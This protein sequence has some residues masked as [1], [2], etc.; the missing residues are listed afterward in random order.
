MI[1]C[2]SRAARELKKIF[3]LKL[4]TCC[5]VESG[6]SR[7]AARKQAINNQRSRNLTED[8]EG[9]EGEGL[10]M[11][12]TKP[13]DDDAKASVSSNMDD[14]GGAMGDET[15]ASGYDNK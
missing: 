12:E 11:T 5:Y 13:G 1:C 10:A 6:L 9:G 14:K 4:Y 15:T 7:R 3:K 2:D 8:I